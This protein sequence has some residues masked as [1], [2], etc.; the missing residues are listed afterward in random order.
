MFSTASPSLYCF[1]YLFLSGKYWKYTQVF[2]PGKPET[3]FQF[4]YSTLY[5]F[6][7]RQMLTSFTS[8]V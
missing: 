7:A 5:P 4:S 1:L 2:T 3:D 8:S 6:D